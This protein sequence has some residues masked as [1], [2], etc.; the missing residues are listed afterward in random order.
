MKKILLIGLLTLV[1]HQLQAACTRVIGYDSAG[2]P[3][4]GECLQNTDHTLIDPIPFDPTLS[5][6]V[7][8]DACTGV[9]CPSDMSCSAG[10]C[11][12]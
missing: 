1:P 2:Y 5:D 9:K 8:T 3:V 10:C 7:G 12:F 6:P 4:L 11:V